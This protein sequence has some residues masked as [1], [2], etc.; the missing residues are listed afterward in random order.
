M[1]QG[2]ENT[3]E[4]NFLD[5]TKAR[6]WGENIALNSHN[7]EWQPKKPMTSYIYISRGQ[8]QKKKGVDNKLKTKAN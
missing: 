7:K 3:I 5:E 8:S 2:N 6:F 1:K 4:Q